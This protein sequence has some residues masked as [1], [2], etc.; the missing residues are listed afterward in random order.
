MSDISAVIFD[1]GNVMVDWQPRTIFE[2]H[3]DD[4]DQLDWFMDTVVSMDWHKHHDAGR[5]FA[6][7]VRLQSEA[8]PD[9]AALIGLYDSQ[10]SDT[11]VGVIDGTIDAIKALKARS[12]PLYGL[13]NFNGPK[14]AEFRQSYDFIDLLDGVVVSGDEGLIKPDP[15][16]FTLT[17]DRFNLQGEK[18]LFIDDSLPN[19]KAAEALGIVGHHFTGAEGLEQ[20]LKQLKLL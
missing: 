18:T 2:P 19:I 20:K 1:V 4:K 11:I 3:F 15:Q 14:F 7:G 8:Y 16:I 12:V 9:Y 13:T 10:W 17:L 5:S 6:E